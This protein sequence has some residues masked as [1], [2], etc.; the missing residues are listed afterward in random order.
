MISRWNSCFP[1]PCQLEVGK[2]MVINISL[3]D[4]VLTQRCGGN[5]FWCFSNYWCVL[6]INYALSIA[7]T[8][9]IVSQ[10]APVTSCHLHI[11]M[12]AMVACLCPSLW[13]LHFMDVHATSMQ[14]C[15]P[16]HFTLGWEA[17]PFTL[18]TFHIDDT[19][20]LF[21]LLVCMTLD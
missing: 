10:A 17:L 6:L 5:L 15:Y 11:R 21:S 12:W 16:S 19:N 3:S 18:S 20:N 2:A 8:Y 13:L 1:R 7:L 9:R 14:H 4:S